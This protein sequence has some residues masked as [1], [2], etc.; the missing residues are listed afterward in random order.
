MVG[1]SAL[2]WVQRGFCREST[3]STTYAHPPRPREPN[4]GVPLSGMFRAP[5][6]CPSSRPCKGL[7][8]TGLSHQ[9]G[10]PS[11]QSQHEK[12]LSPA[13]TTT[14]LPTTPPT[15]PRRCIRELKAHSQNQVSRTPQ[16]RKSSHRPKPSR[17]REGAVPTTTPW[18]FTAP[19]QEQRQTVPLCATSKH[20]AP[21]FFYETNSQRRRPRQKNGTK[22]ASNCSILCQKRTKHEH[23]K[24]LF[25]K[26]TPPAQPAQQLN[27]SAAQRNEPQVRLYRRHVPRVEGFRRSALSII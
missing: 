27:R 1:T 24:P 11:P 22:I 14:S 7:P 10:R 21:A 16:N 13:P 17:D 4:Q 15:A 26:R 25:T 6:I 2:G 9:A 12:I 19:A 5:P 8:P 23:Q 18:P 20:P 3:V